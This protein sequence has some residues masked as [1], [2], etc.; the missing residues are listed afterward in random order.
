MIVFHITR[1]LHLHWEVEARRQVIL[2]IVSS[3]RV[4]SVWC[5][6]SLCR[7]EFKYLL[8]KVKKAVAIESWFKKRQGRGNLFCRVEPIKQTGRRHVPYFKKH[9]HPSL[10]QRLA[11]RDRKPAPCTTVY[12]FCT[13]FKDLQLHELAWVTNTHAHNSTNITG[14][15][16]I[17][18]LICF[19]SRSRDRNWSATHFLEILSIYSCIFYYFVVRDI[20]NTV[21]YRS[22]TR[23][24]LGTRT[25]CALRWTFRKWEIQNCTRTLTHT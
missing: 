23:V 18:V 9:H 6:S 19:Q 20:L 25:V 22:N 12:V 14:V 5:H 21:D 10:L 13:Q 24:R 3:D 17:Y 4:V 2:S 16:G 1:A 8:I 11:F 15:D 7:V